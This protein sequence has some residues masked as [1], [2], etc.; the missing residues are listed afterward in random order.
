MDNT[1]PPSDYQSSLP[2]DRQQQIQQL[3]SEPDIPIPNNPTNAAEVEQFI[4]SPQN[5]L[6]APALLERVFRD[7]KITQ[8]DY[9]RLLQKIISESKLQPEEPV[10]LKKVLT[11][12]EIPQSDYDRLMEKIISDDNHPEAPLN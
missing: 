11:E 9:N 5:I 1:V 3:L 7:G 2:E 12:G 4:S 6:V 10:S 8:S